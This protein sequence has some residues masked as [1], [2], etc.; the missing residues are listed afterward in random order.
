M[1]KRSLAFILAGMIL[2]LPACRRPGRSVFTIGVLQLIESPTAREI[3]RG[4][5][6]ALE[7]YG[8]QNGA[9][10]RLDVR[11]GLGDLSEVQ[12]IARA[13]GEDGV[14]MIIAITTPCLQ[15]A[16][17]AAPRTPIVFTSVA[18]PFLTRAGTTA[19]NHLPNVTGVASTGPIRQTLAFIRE[20]LPAVRRVGTLWTPSELNSEYY[21]GLLRSAADDLGLEIV[22][23]PVAN[24][25]EVLLASQV[26][27]NKRVDAIY[28]I[29][30][31]TVNASFEAL[32]L[33]AAEAGVPLF[34]GFLL[35]TRAG[36][37]AAMGWDFFD[38]GYKTG[39]L[40][41]RIKNGV[42]PARIPFQS[43]TNVQIS[44]NPDTAAKQGIHFSEDIKKRAAEIVTGGSEGE[45]LPAGAAAVP[46]G[47]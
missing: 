1:G 44:L 7:D 35:S 22:T 11:D 26:L 23:V 31:N 6:K 39:S 16:M 45:P 30:D 2:W 24:P 5:V 4:I 10:V 34:G 9:N 14:D 3:R 8:L 25:N 38:M 27:I 41:V 43:M 13:F 17:I 29:S 18:N 21:L 32:G 12:R 15:A 28:Q 19:V 40:A 47:P 46:I 37:C 33:A 42:D 36:A 20:V